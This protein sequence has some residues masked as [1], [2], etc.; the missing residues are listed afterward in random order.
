MAFT[1]QDLGDLLALLRQHPEWRDAVRREVLTEQ[2]IEL[3][4]IVQRLAEADE[5]LATR[6]EQIAE[7]LAQLSSRVDQLTARVEQLTGRL[8]QLTA[9]VEQL[10]AR[11]DQ[12]AEGL[13]QLTARVDGLTAD[14]TELG[15]IV[16]RMDGRLGNLEGW[17]YE[18]R[19]NA[20]ARVLDII[21]RPVE[22]NLA[23]LDLVVDA[24]ASGT[25]TDQEWTQLLA[26]DFLLKGRVGRGADA[27]ETLLALEVPLRTRRTLP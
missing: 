10:T 9:R 3:P 17:R 15:H 24:R 8:D 12:L 13:A 1:G 20:R 23:D 7:S 25:L 6:I 19:F 11:F 22:V 16:A 4:A 5:R 21:R 14:V 2:L 26:L 27:A 18:Q